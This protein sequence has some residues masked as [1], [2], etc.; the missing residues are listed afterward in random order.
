MQQRKINVLSYELKGRGYKALQ[1]TLE[2]DE[3][4]A[5]DYVMTSEIVNCVPFITV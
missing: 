5:T 1:I 3:M 2:R 4:F